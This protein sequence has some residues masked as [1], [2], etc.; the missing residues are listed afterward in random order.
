M[1]V[2]FL[3]GV[4]AVRA[5]AACPGDCNGDG[6]VSV[7]EIVQAV[8]I[9]LGQTAVTECEAVDRNGNGVVSI[10]ELLAAV[11]SLLDGCPGQ[12]TPTASTSSTVTPSATPTPT[13]TGTPT[14]S[15]TPSASPPPTATPTLNLSPILPPASIYRAYPGFDIHVPITATDPE[16]SSV[17]CTPDGLPV[18][19]SFDT[20]GDVLDWTPTSD[21]LGPF[22]LPFL[23]SDDAVPPASAAGQ[24]TF[25]VEPLDGC[26]M[27]ICDP[28]TGCISTLPPPGQFCCAGGPAA[29]VAE[30]AADCPAGRVLYAG[31]NTKSGFGRLQNC[32]VLPMKN[33]QQSGAEVDF[34]IEARCMNTLNRVTLR[35]R[36]DSSSTKHATVFNVQQPPFFLDTEGT[37]NGFA[38]RYNLRFGVNGNGPFT[39][40]EGTEANLTLT[41]TDADGATVTDQV[42]LRLTFTPPAMVPDLPDVDPTDTPLPTCAPGST[43]AA[44][45]TPACVVPSDTPTT[46]ATPTPTTAAG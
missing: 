6:T 42:R 21:Q 38:T 39:D 8:G 35:A 28:A 10:D 5:D 27:P 33:F 17:Q 11:N 19:A 24:L 45:Q 32:D 40:L 26:A 36:L 18:G 34:H 23:C 37:P 15:A 1:A 20:Q 14:P 22:Y 16:G 30:P 2:L 31:R 29:R 13:S 43:P 12:P 46:D 4:V 3:V 41:L 25:A 9:A 7:A 44:D